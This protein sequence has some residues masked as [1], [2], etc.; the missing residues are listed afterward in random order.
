LAA[1]TDVQ[2]VL[3]A[4]NANPAAARVVELQPRSPFP[5][6]V[7]TYTSDANGV[8][9]VSNCWVGD[10]AGRIKAKGQAQEI[11]FQ[12]TVTSSNLGAI[13]AHENTT[14]SGIQ[15]YPSVGRTAPSLQ[16]ADLRYAPIGVTNFIGGTN[17]FVS[18]NDTIAGIKSLTNLI[19][20]IV[21]PVDGTGLIGGRLGSGVLWV[22]SAGQP[23]FGYSPNSFSVY[24]NAFFRNDVFITN[25]VLH[26]TAGAVSAVPLFAQAK[27]G[28]ATNIF[29]VKSSAG[30]PLVYVSESGVLN[31]DGSGLTGVSG[32][33]GLWELDSNGDAMPG[34]GTGTGANWEL[35]SNG[36]LQPL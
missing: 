34:T 11:L 6:N 12:T 15:T 17:Y 33:G 3:S 1:Q 9:W 32:S 26:V 18:G 21:N 20:W 35:D 22:T 13:Y 2:F 7:W 29:E 4:F 36:D 30:I 27:S 19:Q 28:Q 8:F 23:I 24:T 10:I 5:G 25:G 14:V 31:G 16:M